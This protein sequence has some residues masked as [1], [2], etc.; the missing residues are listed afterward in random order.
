MDEITS[1][2]IIGSKASEIS[3]SENI[4]NFY[5]YI[6]RVTLLSVCTVY[7][8]L[9]HCLRFIIVTV[10]N[11]YEN[12]SQ[13]FTQTYR[14]RIS[15][16]R[17]SITVDIGDGWKDCVCANSCCTT[18]PFAYV[19]MIVDPWHKKIDNVD[20]I[21]LFLYRHHSKVVYLCCWRISQRQGQNAIYYKLY[22]RKFRC[23]LS[24]TCTRTSLVQHF[25]SI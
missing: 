14:Y 16:K 5:T 17:L 15:G 7:D 24:Q 18:K 8:T 23:I 4:E 6:A 1:G 25:T 13:Y 2:S 12:D 20:Q 21:F 22:L 9:I 19:K 11:M 3:F 10:S